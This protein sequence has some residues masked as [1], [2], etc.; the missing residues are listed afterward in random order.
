MLEFFLFLNSCSSSFLLEYFSFWFP[1]LESFLLLEFFL[2]NYFNS[3]EFS[4]WILVFFS[5]FSPFFFL[6]LNLFFLNFLFLWI[7]LVE[8]FVLESCFWI[9]FL[10][11]LIIYLNSSF[12][13]LYLYLTVVL[14]LEPF[15]LL[16]SWILVLKFCFLFLFLIDFVIND[17]SEH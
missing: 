14:L 8:S 10:E 4:S 11:P 12:K 13:L 3:F 2:L 7:L 17:N 5:N 16:T 9:L 1:F 15:S 6:F